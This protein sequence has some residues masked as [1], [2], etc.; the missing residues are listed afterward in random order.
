MR[1]RDIIIG[2]AVIVI[3]VAVTRW[4]ALSILYYTR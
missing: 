1:T 2:T 4:V 3:L